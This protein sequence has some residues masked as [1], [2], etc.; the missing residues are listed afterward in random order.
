MKLDGD[1]CR[2]SLPA[3]EPDE[4]S[5]RAQTFVRDMAAGENREEYAS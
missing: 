3:I 4:S 1:G 2:L 5:V